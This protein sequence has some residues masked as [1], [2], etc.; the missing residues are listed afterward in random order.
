MADD[1]NPNRSMEDEQKGRTGENIIGTADPDDANDDEF[2]DTDEMDDNE[3]ATD[4][5]E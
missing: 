2:D 4:E 5:G 3:N 1:R